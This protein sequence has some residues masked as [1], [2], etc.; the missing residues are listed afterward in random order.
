MEYIKT[1]FCS[2]YV[3]L[4][5]FCMYPIWE[6]QQVSQRAHIFWI[7]G[8]IN[9]ILCRIEQLLHINNVKVHCLLFIYSHCLLGCIFLV[10]FT[11]CKLFLNVVGFS[12]FQEIIFDS[13]QQ[14]EH[15]NTIK[16]RY[17]LKQ[18]KKKIFNINGQRRTNLR[19]EQREKS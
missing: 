10:K 17:F 7:D 12:H 8:P 9:I 13:K 1:I 4:N 3:P 6:N 16:N 15:F 11:R 19:T 18:H 5:R 2:F 14:Q